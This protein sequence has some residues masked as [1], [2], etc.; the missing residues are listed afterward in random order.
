MPNY[1]YPTRTIHQ[2]LSGI[3][4]HMRSINPMCPN[5]LDK[6]DGRFRKLCGSCEVVFRQLRQAGVGVSVK[7]TAIITMEEEQ[8]LWEAGVMNVEEPVGLFRAVFLLCWK[9]VLTSWRRRAKEPEN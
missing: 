4:R 7:H 9:G 1:P 3:L 6:K 5:I 2:I 8:R